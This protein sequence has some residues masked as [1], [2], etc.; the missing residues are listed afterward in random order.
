MQFYLGG[1]HTELAVAELD[2]TDGSM[3]VSATV[4][5]PENASF[6]VHAP[7]LN[8]LYATVESGYKN[9]SFGKIAAYRV[10]N[11]GT[12]STLGTVETCGAGPC[13]LDVDPDGR[14]IAAA[15]YGGETF[16][17]IALSEDGTPGATLACVRHSGSSVNEGRQGEPHPH[18][19]TFSPDGQ[20]LFVCD[21]G[22]DELMRYEVARLAG[23]TAGE[24]SSSQAGG[25]VAATLPPGSGPRHIAFSPDNRH[26]YVV[27]ELSSTVVAYTYDAAVG[28][29]SQIHEVSTLP[30]G[31]EGESFCAEIQVHPT[32]RFVYASNRGHESIVAFARDEE[33]GT[34][35][36]AD[37]ASTQGEHPRHFQIE[38][39]GR[40]CLVANTFSNTVASMRVNAES[41]A[42][43]W[44]GKS[45]AATGPSCCEFARQG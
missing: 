13:H 12:L 24:M 19:T 45:I 39:T 33:S 27:N 11:D 16:T 37:F 42:L 3:A 44:T 9:Q 7:R 32:G 23:S 35:T 34:L 26:L 5:T 2:T 28:G 43:E 20:F 21:L 22:T 17:L 40:W 8:A 38:P 4:A 10:A 1:Y 36:P 31:Y 6:L 41:G 14:F 15:N 25:V 29:V 18:A 30:D